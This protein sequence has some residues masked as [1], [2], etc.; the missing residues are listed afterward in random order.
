VT[1]D[2]V[3]AGRELD[4]LVAEQVMGFVRVTDDTSDYNHVRHGNEVLLPPGATLHS[5]REWLP[6]KG[7]I[8]FGYFVT[9]RYST[10]IAAARLVEDEIERRGLSSEYTGALAVRIR[11]DLWD[12]LRA[13]PE[14]RCRAALVVVRT[15]RGET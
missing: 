3:P 9:Q 2:N 7:Q 8:P 6:R 12:L 13:T 11:G 1:A 15:V 5:L 4:V 14:Q 10:D